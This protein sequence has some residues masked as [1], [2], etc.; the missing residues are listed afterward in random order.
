MLISLTNLV[1]SLAQEQK[2]ILF[3]ASAYAVLAAVLNV[4]P[5]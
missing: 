2:I 4:H 1:Y 5:L 3:S